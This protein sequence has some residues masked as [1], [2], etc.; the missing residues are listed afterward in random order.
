LAAVSRHDLTGA[1][2]QVLE[3]LLPS[4]KRGHGRPRD[5][6][7]KCLNGILYMLKPSSAWTD[8]PKE[9]GSPTN[10]WRRFSER[11]NLDFYR[12]VMSPVD[13]QG[14]FSNSQAQS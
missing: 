11:S 4:P 12:F 13:F 2:W 6:S 10:Y 7:R 1:Q 3:P 8:L 5:D 14:F 9:Y